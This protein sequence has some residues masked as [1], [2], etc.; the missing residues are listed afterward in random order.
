MLS[1]P[2][3]ARITIGTTCITILK[4][5]QMSCIHTKTKQCCLWHVWLKGNKRVSKVFPVT[6]QRQGDLLSTQLGFYCGQRSEGL[7]VRRRD[8]PC[9]SCGRVRWNG[10]NTAGPWGW[11]SRWCPAD[12]A[13]TPRVLGNIYVEERK[14]WKDR[15]E[16]FVQDYYLHSCCSFWFTTYFDKAM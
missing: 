16:H 10:C 12:W 7:E 1:T 15:R 4:E 5:K 14:R 6:R 3:S 9:T 13:A 11:C 8:W 2:P